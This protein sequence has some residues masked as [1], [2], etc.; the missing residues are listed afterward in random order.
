MHID[1]NTLKF[2]PEVLKE[3]IVRF[4]DDDMP[5]HAAAL[6]YYMVFSLPSMLLIVLW[7]SARFYDEVA[8][9][10]AIFAKIGGLVGHQGAGQIMATLEKL[11]VEQPTFWST[12][13]GLGILLFFATSVFDAMRTALNKIANVQTSDSV[14][15]STWKLLRIR[16][17]AFALLV[18]ISF[19]LLVSMV[20]HALITKI[21]DHLVSWFGEVAE[22]IVAFDFILLELGTISLLFALYFRYLPDNRLRWRDIWLG[23]ALTAGLLI[24]GKSLIAFFIS[25]STVA[26]LYDAAGSILVLMLWVYYSSA[27]LLLGA[28][29]TFTRA[30][31]LNNGRDKNARS[32]ARQIRRE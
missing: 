32:F 4:F 13:L 27:I 8:V 22:F 21:S 12:A 28:T 11:S 6:S 1:S 14:M 24:M 5:M 2:Y 26:G 18:S 20:I 19:I 16:F 30:E 25:N 17:I 23:A 15:R 10:E 31:L 7:T 9:R 3:S 29:F